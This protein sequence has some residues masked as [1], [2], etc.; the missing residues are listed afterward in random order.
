[1]SAVLR[2]LQVEDS[3]SDAALVVRLLEKAGYAVEAQ[4]V[5]EATGMRAALAQQPWDFIICDYH[6]P[7]LTAPP[8]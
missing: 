1:M 7:Q 4:R 6:L 2:V 8:L 3:E 5:E